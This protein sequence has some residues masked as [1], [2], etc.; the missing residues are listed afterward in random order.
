MVQNFTFTLL[1]KSKTSSELSNS[2]QQ[3]FMVFEILLFRMLAIRKIGAINVYRTVVTSIH[4]ESKYKSFKYR[5]GTVPETREERENRK[6]WESR[7]NTLRKEYGDRLPRKFYQKRE[8]MAQEQSIWERMGAE[9]RESLDEIDRGKT[10]TFDN[11]RDWI[12]SKRSNLKRASAK[13]TL[14]GLDSSMLIGCSG[15]GDSKTF[16]QEGFQIDARL[17]ALSANQI[18]A[19]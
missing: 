2:F 11:R 10:E 15:V 14:P 12:A 18:A 6:Y 3:H 16:T 19:H 8:Q 1:F 17:M 9:E 5:K 13:Y 7:Q 4:C